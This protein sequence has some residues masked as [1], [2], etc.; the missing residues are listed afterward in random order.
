MTFDTVGSNITVTAPETSMT[1]NCKN[2]N[3]NVGENGRQVWE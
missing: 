2:M 1:F 3:I